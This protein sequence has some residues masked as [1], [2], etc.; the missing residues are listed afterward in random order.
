MIVD[1]RVSTESSH[2]NL[3][4]QRHHHAVLVVVTFSSYLGGL[5]HGVYSSRISRVP[6][7]LHHR[8]VAE[9]LCARVDMRTPRAQVHSALMAAKCYPFGTSND[10][11]LLEWALRLV[12]KEVR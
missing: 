2:E 11:T 9:R 10:I 12:E 1:E 6:L 3:T 5:D 7:G 8:M 4:T